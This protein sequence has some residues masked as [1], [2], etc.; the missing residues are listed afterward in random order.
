MIVTSIALRVILETPS[1]TNYKDFYPHIQVYIPD[2][3]RTLC[4]L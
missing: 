4:D 1:S 3:N 2:K